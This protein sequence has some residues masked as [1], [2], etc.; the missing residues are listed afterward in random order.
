M[1]INIGLVEIKKIGLPTNTIRNI[2]YNIN[3]KNKIDPV[4]MY[5]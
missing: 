3:Y 4:L 2:N 1:S 5:E